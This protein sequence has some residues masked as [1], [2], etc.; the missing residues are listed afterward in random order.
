[1]N[2]EKFVSDFKHCPRAKQ[3]IELSLNEKDWFNYQAL[4]DVV[5]EEARKRNTNKVK[6]YQ[7]NPS[8]TRK[9]ILYLIKIGFLLADPQKGLKT[10]RDFVPT[11][12]KDILN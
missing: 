5:T 10:N 11:S 8:S 1:M 4:F 12:Q 2:K 3:I 9:N 7:G 6:D